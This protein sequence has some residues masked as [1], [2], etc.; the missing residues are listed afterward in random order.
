M[1][2]F[3][4][5]FN[6]K[7][8]SLLVGGVFLFTS[9]AYA[10]DSSQKTLLRVQHQ[11]STEQGRNRLIEV[12]TQM[13][14]HDYVNEYIALQGETRYEEFLESQGIDLSLKDNK[15]N[16]DT[17][18]NSLEKYLGSDIAIMSIDGLYENTRILEHIGLGRFYGKPIIYIDSSLKD[19]DREE[20]L[21]HAY[22]E[23]TKWDNKRQSLGLE[24]SQMREYILRK[25]NYNGFVQFAK[26]THESSHDINNILKKYEAKHK[27]NLL[28]VIATMPFK[29]GDIV[30]AGGEPISRR[31]FFKKTLPVVAG[32]MV[33]GN[34]ITSLEAQQI[35]NGPISFDYLQRYREKELELIKIRN[36]RDLPRDTIV[37]LHQFLIQKLGQPNVDT[38]AV[39]EEG[40]KG[41]NEEIQK[42]KKDNIKMAQEG[43]SFYIAKNYPPDDRLENS[44]KNKEVIKERL[45]EYIKRLEEIGVKDFAIYSAQ[46]DLDGYFMNKRFPEPIS[47]KEF[48]Y[49]HRKYYYVEVDQALEV[50]DDII[51][52]IEREPIAEECL[53]LNRVALYINAYYDN[54]KVKQYIIDNNI[55]KR[56]YGLY[57]YK[58]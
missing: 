29:E 4:K 24:W 40:I 32:V 1:L 3:R 50:I 25:E 18:Y 11:T 55:L 34:N 33:A 45:E 28:D 8:I 7:I 38:N 14:Y 42:K 21:Q 56:L 19:K 10:I 41:L 37:G 17:F 20:I 23:I 16:I 53:Y 44:W 57:R 51:N 30:I 12:L 39:Y 15:E 35:D 46:E 47:F 26:E 9:T 27:S 48:L 5:V 22:L 13:T 52:G 2:K 58:G 49:S 6:S 31:D 54:P 43:T 36:I